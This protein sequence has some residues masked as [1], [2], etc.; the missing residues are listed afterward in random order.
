MVLLFG[1]GDGTDDL[2]LD[3]KIT[4]PVCGKKATLQAYCDYKAFCLFFLPVYKWDKR[5]YVRTSCCG[6]ICG[7]SP[8]EGEALDEGDLKKLEVK[9]LPLVAPGG[10]VRLKVCA[11]CGYETS[12]PFRFCPMCGRPLP[13]EAKHLR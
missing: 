6:A 4:C 2:Y 8:Q 1:S 10:A 12:Q 9:K 3:Q 5:F 13:D 7:I 11:S